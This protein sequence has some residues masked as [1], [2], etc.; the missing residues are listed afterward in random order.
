MSSTN[1]IK[2]FVEGRM[3]P[4]EFDALLQSSDN[5]ETDLASETNIPPYTNEGNLFLYLLNQNFNSSNDLLN[6]Q[7][8]LSKYLTKRGLS[9]QVAESVKAQARLLALVQP[10]WLDV[11]PRYLEALVAEAEGK[12]GQEL[13]KWLKAEIGKRFRYIKSPPKWL[14]APSWPIEDGH[15][16]I[17]VGQMDISGLRH[18]NSQVYVF[19]TPKGDKLSTVVQSM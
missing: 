9:H 5:L 19:S 2:D 4:R 8:A 18:D 11:P 13:Q 15:P 3:P 7:D 1:I 17:F 10:K 12:A 6:I 14:Q 16:M